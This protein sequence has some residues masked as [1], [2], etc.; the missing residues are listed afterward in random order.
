MSATVAAAELLT[1][2]KQALQRQTC[3]RINRRGFCRG[4]DVMDLLCNGRFLP[5]HRIGIEARRPSD[6]AFDYRL[7]VRFPHAR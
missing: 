4:K 6:L 3:R 5:R 7:H 1:P 2:I